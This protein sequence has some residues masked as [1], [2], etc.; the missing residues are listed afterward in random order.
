M[1]KGILFVVCAALSALAACAGG[2]RPEPT[3]LG[4]QVEPSDQYVTR[5]ARMAEGDFQREMA[6]R[7][8]WHEPVSGRVTP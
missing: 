2:G 5:L 3:G 4:F 8:L 1:S 6:F 7:S